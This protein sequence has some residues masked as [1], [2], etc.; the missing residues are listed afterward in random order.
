VTCPRTHKPFI[1]LTDED[2]DKLRASGVHSITVWRWQTKQRGPCERSLLR[3][4]K[5]LHRNFVLPPRVSMTTVE[6]P[7]SIVVPA[8]NYDSLCL[9]MRRVA[10]QGVQGTLMDQ[11]REIPCASCKRGAERERNEAKRRAI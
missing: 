11:R 2:A 10:F 1:N 9:A 3:I 8:C 7:P 5:I 4:G 6:R